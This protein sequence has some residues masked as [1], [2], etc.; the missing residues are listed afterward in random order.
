MKKILLFIGFCL[1]MISVAYADTINFIDVRSNNPNVTDQWCKNHIHGKRVLDPSTRVPKVLVDN[2]GNNYKRLRHEI[3]VVD[4]FF[5]YH[6]TDMVTGVENGKPWKEI[7]DFLSI[8]TSKEGPY[9]GVFKNNL[10]KGS[11]TYIASH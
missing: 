3:D 4:G 1:G 11:Y 6:G 5:T 9:V 10:C 8:G 7:D 2:E